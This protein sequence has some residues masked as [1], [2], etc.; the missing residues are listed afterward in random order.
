LHFSLTIKFIT[1]YKY[2]RFD[3]NYNDPR[4]KKKTIWNVDAVCN[5]IDCTEIVIQQKFATLKLKFNKE[6]NYN[7]KVFSYIKKKNL[8]FMNIN[9]ICTHIV[10]L[11][12]VG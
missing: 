1:C 4:K 7:V 11:Y 3:S 10:I 2:A 5:T 9:A 6:I 8:T 12:H